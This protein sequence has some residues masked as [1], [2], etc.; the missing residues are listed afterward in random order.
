MTEP[1]QN[2]DNITQGNAQD[3]PQSPSI[4]DSPAY[5]AAHVAATLVNTL[6]QGTGLPTAEARL[7]PVIDL[8]AGTEAVPSCYVVPVTFGMIRNSRASYQDT[9]GIAFILCVEALDEA[10]AQAALARMHQA[11][12]HLLDT[13]EY[14]G[15]KFVS[16]DYPELFDYELLANARI[17]R[18]QA[19]ISCK[20]FEL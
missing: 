14:Y 3:V 9:L 1:A 6:W 18:S 13:A 5:T 19:N 20:V 16:A 17:F 15:V 10:A 8:Q 2:Q 11:V 7:S 12:R 4:P